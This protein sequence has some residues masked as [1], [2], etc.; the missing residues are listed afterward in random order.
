MKT[1]VLADLHLTDNFNTVKLPMLDWALHEARLRRCD[2]LCCIGELTARGSEAQTAEVLK[3][4]DACAIP[5]CSTPG[6]AELRIYP[7]GRTAAKFD[8][9][10]PDGLPVVLIDTAKTN[11]L[12]KSRKNLRL[13]RIWQ[14]FCGKISPPI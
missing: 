3:H 5:Y 14:A 13:C 1:A 12:R 8:L 11:P 6:N 4:L 2:W 7:D 9:P 10:P